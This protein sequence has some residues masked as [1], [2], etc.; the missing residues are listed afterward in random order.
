MNL[1]F[2]KNKSVFLTGHSGF[3][4]SWLALWLQSLGAEVVGYALPPPTYPNLFE[5]AGV[6]GGMESVYGDVRDLPHLKET[7][8]RYKP[9]IVIHMAAQSLVRRSYVDPV[10]TYSI[11]VMGTVHIL[12]AI[13]ASRGVKAVVVVTSDKCYD[14]RE[15]L[16]ACREQDAMGGRDPY[17]SS[18]GCAELV[19]A[20]F[21]E[22]FFK[23]NNV[24]LASARAGNVIG[25]GDWAQDRLVPD[26]V[27]AISEGRSVLIRNPHSVRPWQHVLE[28]LRGYLQLAERLYFDSSRYAEGWNFGPDE[29]D[30][31]SV[32]RVVRYFINLWGDG[33]AWELDTRGQPPEARC[34]KLSC[35]KAKAKLSWHPLWSL[36]KG[37]EATASWYKAYF[38][39]KD[40][41][42]LSLQQI[43]EYQQTFQQVVELNS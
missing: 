38:S 42:R 13:R 6:A 32:D 25:G 33:V 3:K 19:V 36:D 23:G 11:N 40:V 4:G 29:G 16:Y 12:E 37:L 21:R 22:A 31:W 1:Q 14:N 8:N 17:S 5:A 7:I 9:A 18:K 15:S 41:R 28:P 24:G 20:A 39:N 30:Q 35:A 10:E 2:W 43:E 27:K 26:I 34:L